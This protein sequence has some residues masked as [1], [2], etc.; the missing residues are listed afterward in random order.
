LGLAI[1]RRIVHEHQGDLRI[2]SEIGKGTVVRIVLPIA[3]G[4]NVT[5]W[6]SAGTIGRLGERG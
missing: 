3:H 1:C 5:H 2:T 6:R 4:A